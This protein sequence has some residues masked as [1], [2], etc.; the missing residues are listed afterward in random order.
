MKSQIIRKLPHFSS[1]YNIF[2]I[3][4]TSQDFNCALLDAW[5]MGCVHGVACNSALTLQHQTEALPASPLFELQSL[6]IKI[7]VR[8]LDEAKTINDFKGQN[9]LTVQHQIFVCRIFSRILQGVGGRG[10]Y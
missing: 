3:V 4:V 6:M 1:F 2:K 10:K 5:T 7:A 8:E 9:I